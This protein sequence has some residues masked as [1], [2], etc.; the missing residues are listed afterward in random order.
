MKAVYYESQGPALDVLQVGEIETPV[1]AQGEVLVRLKTSGVNP[2]DVKARSG[3]RPGGMPYPRI[4][5]HSDGAGVIEAVGDGVSAARIGERVWIWNGQWQR[6]FGTAAGYITL[7]SAQA[8]LLPDNTSFVDAASLGIPAST[9]AHAVHQG[10]SGARS[11][12]VN[13]ANGTVGRLAIQFAAK[14]GARVIA[15]T[16]DL[17][18]ADRLR[19]LGADAVFSYRDPD[20]A[21]QILSANEG[22]GIDRITEVELCANIGFDAEVI[23]PGGRIVA[24]GSQ[25]NMNPEI[26]FGALM[27]KNTTLVAAIVYLLNKDDRAAAVHHVTTALTE[28]WLQLPLDRVLPLEACAEAHRLVETNT[29]DGAVVLDCEA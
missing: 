18:E 26:P 28:G 7:P 22:Q 5:P 23:A 12:L 19:S 13:G 14:T 15:T 21:K 6:P 20:V 24:F 8:V 11:I 9:A 29:R 1:A 4:I 3:S 2:S 25:L 10:G 16:G 27:F 17:A